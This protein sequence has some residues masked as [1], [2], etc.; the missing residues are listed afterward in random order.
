VRWPRAA[1]GTWPSPRGVGVGEGAGGRRGC[2]TQG[3]SGRD[4][5]LAGGPDPMKI[6]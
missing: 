6:K 3:P 2:C 5:D 1:A 4:T